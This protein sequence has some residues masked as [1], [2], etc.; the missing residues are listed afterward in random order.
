MRKLLFFDVDGTLADRVGKKNGMFAPRIIPGAC[1]SFIRP[2]FTK[3]T[4][5]TVVALED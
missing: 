3:L 2:E 1:A 4:T 5:I